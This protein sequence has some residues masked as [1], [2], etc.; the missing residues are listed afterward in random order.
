MLAEMPGEQLFELVFLGNLLDDHVRAELETAA[1]IGLLPLLGNADLRE[2]LEKLF[3]GMHE[4]RIARG[5]LAD[6]R[7]LGHVELALGVVYTLEL[8]MD[9]FEV[10]HFS[11]GDFA[12]DLRNFDG[13]VEVHNGAKIELYPSTQILP[14]G[15]KKQGFF[16][17]KSGDYGQNTPGGR[18]LS[19]ETTRS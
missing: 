14:K 4:R 18:R 5:S 3:I 1:S 17:E 11:D 15:T 6:D 2:E 19:R 9:I 13:A 12:L 16:E 10:A 8:V 7:A